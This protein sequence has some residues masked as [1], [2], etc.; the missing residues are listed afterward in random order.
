MIMKINRSYLLILLLSVMAWPTVVKAQVVIRDQLIS[1][2]LY[3]K[4]YSV[5]AITE[6]GKHRL[7]IK[8]NKDITHLGI[9]KN[10]KKLKQ[11]VWHDYKEYAL[12]KG[13]RSKLLKPRLRFRRG[14]VYKI[15]MQ[16]EGE[17]DKRTFY[18]RTRDPNIEMPVK[19]ELGTPLRN[20]RYVK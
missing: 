12:Y 13:L 15:E 9:W 6:K 19:E 1:L 20:F 8:H 4:I 14:T 3:N 2:D 17:A 5:D 18:I 7:A 16:L 10:G 11:T